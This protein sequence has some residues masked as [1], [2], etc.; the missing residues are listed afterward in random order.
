MRAQYG[1]G[2]TIARAA[3]ERRGGRLSIVSSVGQGTTVQVTL[4]R[5]SSR[6]AAP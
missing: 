4:P 6:P 1:L 3:A 2:L 5:W